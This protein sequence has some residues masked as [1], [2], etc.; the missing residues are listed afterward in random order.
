[1]TIHP[2]CDRAIPNPVTGNTPVKVI[3]IGLSLLVKRPARQ[4]LLS[5]IPIMERLHRF[6]E[7]RYLELQPPHECGNIQIPFLVGALL[8][9]NRGPHCLWPVVGK[10]FCRMVAVT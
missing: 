7:A 10:G 8:D 4:N 3:G 5:A 1:M 9:K 6:L 2:I